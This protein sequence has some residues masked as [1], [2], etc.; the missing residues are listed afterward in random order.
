MTG[1]FR[2]TRAE[3]KKI[4]K[5]P[6][7]FIMALILVATI[8]VSLY[9]FNKNGLNNSNCPTYSHISNANYNYNIISV[10]NNRYERHF[11]S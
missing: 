2:L 3:F 1:T 10:K 9:V 7:V 11:N 6:S 5:R 4:F 8:F